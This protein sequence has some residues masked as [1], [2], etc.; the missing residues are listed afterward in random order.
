[1]RHLEADGAGMRRAADSDALLCH[2]VPQPHSA[3]LCQRQQQVGPAPGP[4]RQWPDDKANTPGGLP[5]TGQIRARP[6]RPSVEQPAANSSALPR[7]MMG[8]ACPAGS[9]APDGCTPGVAGKAHY[10]AQPSN[11]SCGDGTAACVNRAHLAAHAA[12]SS[13][14]LVWPFSRHTTE[15]DV[16]LMRETWQSLPP[17]ASKPSPSAST[18]RPPEPDSQQQAVS[19]YKWAS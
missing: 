2:D 14:S 18:G 12:K 16:M 1:M 9:R 6:I 17:T 11:S 15:V 5:G 4:H 13:S 8:R 10:R 19:S 3:V 7:L